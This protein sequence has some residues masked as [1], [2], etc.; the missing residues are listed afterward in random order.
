M[1]IRL[2]PEAIRTLRSLDRIPDSVAETSR[3]IAD[4]LLNSVLHTSLERAV[5]SI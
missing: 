2:S 1:Y 5:S 3:T 4:E